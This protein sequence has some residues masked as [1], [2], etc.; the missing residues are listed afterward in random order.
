MR[1][2]L[3]VADDPG[4]PHAGRHVDT[5]LADSHRPARVL[6][7]AVD[8]TRRAALRSQ[9]E[10]Y[11][12]RRQA[13]ADPVDVLVY[14]VPD[15]SPYAIFS[16]VNPILDLISSGLGYLGGMIEAVGRPGC[17]VVMAAPARD[18]WDRV[19]HASYP[20]VWERILATHPLRRLRHVGRVIVAAPADET[21]P[22]H[23]GWETAPSVE[24]AVARARL[25]HGPG[26]TVACVEQPPIVG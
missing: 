3:D 18:Q 8:E 17:T 19:A 20:E 10:R 4:D 2:P 23:L 11:P 24:D 12:P 21:V 13:S 26:A 14:G 6:A 7:G 1:G 9:A 25:V 15:S 22:R 16:S 5:L